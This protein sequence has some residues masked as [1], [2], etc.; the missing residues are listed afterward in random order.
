MGDYTVSTATT[1]G[2]RVLE[3]CLDNRYAKAV[4]SPAL[5]Y[6][7][8]TLDY[9]MP[10]SAAM[11]E[12]Q[13]AVTRLYN[14]NKRVYTH[15]YDATFIQLTKQHLQFERMI[16]KMVSLRKLLEEMYS[17]RKNQVVSVVSENTLVQRCQT[18]LR[19]NNWSIEVIKIIL[20]NITRCPWFDNNPF[21]LLL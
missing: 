17:M 16:E 9:Y 14:I 13:D 18:Y 4:T 8:K 1:C 15:V 6:A 7:E 2:T 11:V 20:G 5:N 21:L 12:S 10:C 3:T 19:E